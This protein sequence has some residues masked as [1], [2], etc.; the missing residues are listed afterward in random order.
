M[1]LMEIL[2][3]KEIVEKLI[4]SDLGKYRDS[5]NYI[6]ILSKIEDIN[7][8]IYKSYQVCIE[9]DESYKDKVVYV[10][11]YDLLTED[12]TGKTWEIE[13]FDLYIKNSDVIAITDV[14]EI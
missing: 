13:D 1:I 8:D 6:L 14:I 12:V 7:D 4:C 2:T 10:S 11:E 5:F 3:M 9:N